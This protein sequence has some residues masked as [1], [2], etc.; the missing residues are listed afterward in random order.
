M[1]SKDQEK[2][3]GLSVD[4]KE[5]LTIIHKLIEAHSHACLK[6]LL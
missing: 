3:S 6:T 1:T 4:R 5:S 2:T